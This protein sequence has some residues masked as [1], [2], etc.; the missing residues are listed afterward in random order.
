MGLR[1]SKFFTGVFAIFMAFLAVLLQTANGTFIGLGAVGGLFLGLLAWTLQAKVEFGEITID[2]L[3]KDMPF[4]AGNVAAIMGGLLIALIGSLVKPDTEFKWF[5]LN[6]RIPLVDDIEPPKAED[7]SISRLERQVKIAYYA[8]ITLTV[9]MIILWPLPLHFG[10]GVFSTGG[11]T[12][13][14]ILEIVWAVLGGITIIVLPVYETVRDMR[15]SK[16]MLM[17]ATEEK[18]LRNGRSINVDFKTL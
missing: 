14:V 1:M 2:T 11:F 3:G 6:D 9:I 8:S 18:V 5:M 10:G 13:W 17:M 4:V 15:E 16:K 12:F 7:E